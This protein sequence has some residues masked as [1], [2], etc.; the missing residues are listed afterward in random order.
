MEPKITVAQ[1][2]EWLNEKIKAWDL[3]REAPNGANRVCEAYRESFAKFSQIAE[4][5]VNDMAGLIE[6]K[7]GFIWKAAFEFY[8][9]DHFRLYVKNPGMLSAPKKI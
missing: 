3:G 6:L 4:P 9:T 1:F 8:E 7:E 2:K 5:P